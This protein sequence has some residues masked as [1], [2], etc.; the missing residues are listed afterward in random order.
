MKWNARNVARLPT[1]FWFGHASGDRWD[2]NGSRDRKKANARHRRG[3][4]FAFLEISAHKKTERN[5]MKGKNDTNKAPRRRKA[6]HHIRGHVR[7]TQANRD[8]N[9]NQTA[10]MELREGGQ[11]GRRASNK[12]GTG[13]KERGSRERKPSNRR[14]ADMVQTMAEE[15]GAM[16]MTRSSWRRDETKTRGG[17]EEE[18]EEEKEEMMMMIM[19]MMRRMWKK[20][21]R[22]DERGRDERKGKG[23]KRWTS[24]NHRN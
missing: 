16:T 23:R 8:T 7:P 20:E 5:K 24:K 15:S 11:G 18:E 19:M 1:I 9:A 3:I 12:K 4:L 17:N 21:T 2:H 6:K 22:R 14:W 10:R 13:R